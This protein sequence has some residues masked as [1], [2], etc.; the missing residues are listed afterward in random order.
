[1]NCLN[2]FQGVGQ[3][4]GSQGLGSS[5]QSNLDKSETQDGDTIDNPYLQPIK[6][7]RYKKFKVA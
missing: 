6:L 4:S 2:V 5:H 1:M 3:S 7:P